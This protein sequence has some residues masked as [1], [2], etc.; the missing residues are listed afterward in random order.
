MGYKQAAWN[1]VK[2]FLEPEW[3]LINW[4]YLLSYLFP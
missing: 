1:T 3:I 2:T 4:V